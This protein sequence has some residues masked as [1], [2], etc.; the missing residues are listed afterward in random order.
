MRVIAGSAKG[1][2][3]KAVPGQNTRPTTDKV[4]ESIF[5]MIGPY[6]DGGV[7]LDLFAGTG[8]LAIEA[9]SR[10]MEHGVLIDHNKQSIETIRKNVIATNMNQRVEIYHNDA[11]RALKILKKR[12]ALFD[13]VFLDPP[14]RMKVL[15]EIL[16]FLIDQK[17]LND[18]ALIV[19]EHDAKYSFQNLE[20]MKE[21]ELVKDV[22]YGDIGITIFRN[23]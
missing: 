5:N 18:Q 6:F 11:F 8:G 4:K 23:K 19:T 12:G 10:G 13:L 16:F 17:L 20:Q 9:L 1:R 2:I 7:V 22:T 15:E 3:L 14:Y 21:L